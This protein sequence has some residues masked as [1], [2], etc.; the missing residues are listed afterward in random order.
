MRK[1]ADVRADVRYD[2]TRKDTA[3]LMH[4]RLLLIQR[5]VVCDEV[6]AGRGLPLLS[7]MMVESLNVAGKRHRDEPMR[8]PWRRTFE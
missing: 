3:W 7:P 2:Y 8:R 1:M 5:L 4:K 6:L